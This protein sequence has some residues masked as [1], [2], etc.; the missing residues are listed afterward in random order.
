[1]SM[2]FPCIGSKERHHRHRRHQA[3][4]FG[5]LKV[6]WAISRSSPGSSPPTHG[7]DDGDDW[8]TQVS[9]TDRHPIN[10]RYES[11]FSALPVRGD[12]GDADFSLL[13][14]QNP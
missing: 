14:E 9:C 5:G 8:V 7:D 2:A 10:A 13:A 4:F 12:D 6:T 11:V 1:M 3:P